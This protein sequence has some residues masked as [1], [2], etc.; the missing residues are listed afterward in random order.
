MTSSPENNQDQAYDYS[1]KSLNETPSS[2]DLV[3]RRLTAASIGA[4]VASMASHI[5]PSEVKP[6]EMTLPL[7]SVVVVEPHKMAPIS[8]SVSVEAGKMSVQQPQCII[9]G[10]STPASRGD[11]TPQEPPEVIQVCK[12]PQSKHPFNK[13]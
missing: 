8:K 5:P 2:P 10:A 11:L 7:N 1:Y 12:L 6:R 13:T 9:S 3:K 4:D